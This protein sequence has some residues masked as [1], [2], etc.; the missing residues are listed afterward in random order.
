MTE[1]TKRSDKVQELL[2]SLFWVNKSTRFGSE[3]EAITKQQYVTHQ[4]QNCMSI[5]VDSLCENDIWLG[6][7]PDGVVQDSDDLNQLDF[8]K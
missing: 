3:M 8:L 2:Y 7:S 5:S 6:A 1:I 4:Q